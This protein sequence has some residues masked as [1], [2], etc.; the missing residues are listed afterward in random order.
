MSIRVLTNKD[1]DMAVL[2]ESCSD[3]AFGPVIYADGV[4]AEKLAEHFI[5]WAALR[6]RNR[7]T[8]WSDAMLESKWVEFSQLGWHECKSCY[9]TLITSSEVECEKCIQTCE[10]CRDTDVE[11]KPTSRPGKKTARLCEKCSA[12][13]EVP[14][15]RA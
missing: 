4:S 5:E 6:S 1:D 2:Y 11:T 15:E 7:F 10:E 14:N 9:D 13:I 8:D 3:W 12:P